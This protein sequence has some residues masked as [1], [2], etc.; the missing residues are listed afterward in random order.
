MPDTDIDTLDRIDAMLGKLERLG[1]LMLAALALIISGAIWAATMQSDLAAVKAEQR[2]I[3]PKVE[4]ALNS[5]AN[6]EG[7]LHGI[8]SQV[9]RVPGR[10]AEKLQPQE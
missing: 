5:I 9:G 2:E 4:T 8:A 7:R 1:K 10:V 3:R 6:I